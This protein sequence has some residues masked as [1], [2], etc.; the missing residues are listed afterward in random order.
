MFLA[1]ELR[2]L[3]YY[4][5]VAD[6]VLPPDH[7]SRRHLPALSE[8]IM[9]NISVSLTR[10]ETG[11]GSGE[12]ETHETVGTAAAAQLLG[13]TQRRIQQR[14]KTG[15]IPAKIVGRTYV[16]ERKDLA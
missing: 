11:A 8:R 12:S 7:E 3:H 5:R 10:N 15:E 2:V 9:D 4:V 6:S 14:I 16:I 1:A 13:C